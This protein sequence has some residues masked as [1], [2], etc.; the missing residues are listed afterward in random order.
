MKD[1]RT[2]FP[3]A[4][5]QFKDKI[6][7]R[8]DFKEDAKKTEGATLKKGKR[9]RVIDEGKKGTRKLKN[10]IST[11]GGRVRS[12]SMRKYTKEALKRGSSNVEVTK[13]MGTPISVKKLG[14]KAKKVKKV[15]KVKGS[16]YNIQKGKT[17]VPKL[18]KK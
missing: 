17:N 11:K 14:E 10:E 12:M 2:S 16:K 13:I 6:K 9:V 5:T 15:K 1:H 7:K 18:R 3:L 4:K 8:K